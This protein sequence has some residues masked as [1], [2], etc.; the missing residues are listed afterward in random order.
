M[1]SLLVK[2]PLLSYTIMAFVFSW[3]LWIPVVFSGP[4]MPFWVSI[5]HN[6]GG[7][8]PFAAALIMIRSSN[9]PEESQTFKQRLLRWQLPIKWYAV[10]LLLPLG[11]IAASYLALVLMGGSLQG[12]SGLPPVW[13]YPLML[14]FMVLLGGGLEEP[15][16]RGYALPKLLSRYSPLSASLMLGVV[17]AFWH[18]PLFWSSSTSQSSIP[19]T[20][21]VLTGIGFSVIFSWCYLYTNGSILMAIILHGGINAALNWFPMGTNTVEPFLPITIVVVLVSTVLALLSPQFTQQHRA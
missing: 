1:K 20:L 18:L 10:V 7:L 3:V 4:E 19:L 11:I 16:W 2:H 12:L 17:W 14:L 5:F 21:F 6:L 9:N 15:G 8:G 13:A